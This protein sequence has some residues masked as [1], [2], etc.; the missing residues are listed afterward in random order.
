[1]HNV[2]TQKTT[3]VWNF[4]NVG[5][6]DVVINKLIFYFK[7]WQKYVIFKYDSISV[8][9]GKDFDHIV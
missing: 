3:N 9:I 2:R 1:M 7:L 4:L 6:K 5:C 8:L